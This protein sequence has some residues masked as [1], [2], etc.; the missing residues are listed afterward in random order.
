MASEAGGARAIR[1]LRFK[2][3][4]LELSQDKC[5]V[6]L[7]TPVSQPMCGVLQ[8]YGV[9]EPR[10]LD[11]QAGE[12]GKSR[13]DEESG[14]HIPVSVLKGA[15][16][17]VSVLGWSQAGVSEGRTN[18]GNESGSS[19]GVRSEE[20]ASGMARD[21]RR[22]SGD[23]SEA[24]VAADSERALEAPRLPPTRQSTFLGCI[25]PFKNVHLASQNAVRCR[26]LARDQIMASHSWPHAA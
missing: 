18:Q 17:E 12:H 11:P 8:S 5:D 2:R 26:S 16:E 20:V 14:D 13:F 6:S 19:E 4:D 10:R 3:T 7:E 21:F 22:E 25:F 24:S 23:G 1:V 15:A 9:W